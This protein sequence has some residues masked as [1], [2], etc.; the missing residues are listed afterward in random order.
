MVCPAFDEAVRQLHAF[1]RAQGES[2]DPIWLTRDDIVIVGRTCVVRIPDE[3][4]ALDQ[5]RKRYEEGVSRGLGV[6]M[7]AFSTVGTQLGCEVWFPIDRGKAERQLMPANL[8]LSIRERLYNMSA[9][10]SAAF[11]LLKLIGR[12][13]AGAALAESIEPHE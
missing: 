1:L 11:G 5:A 7:L 6:M 8:K 12:R 2:R 4:I 9:V 10:R 3:S 13:P